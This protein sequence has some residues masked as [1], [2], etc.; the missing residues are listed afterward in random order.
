MIPVKGHKGLFRD[1]KTG[2]IARDGLTE[3]KLDENFR[4]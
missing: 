4:D 2:A 1:E 3:L